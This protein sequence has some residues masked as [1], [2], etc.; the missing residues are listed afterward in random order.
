MASK[1]KK[2]TRKKELSL[3]EKMQVIHAEN[4]KKADEELKKALAEREVRA[5]KARDSLSEL[6]D[7]SIDTLK[8]AHSLECLGEGEHKAWN[9]RLK[10]ALETIKFNGFLYDPNKSGENTTVINITNLHATKV[11]S[12]AR[13]GKDG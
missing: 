7:K 10:A 3:A 6:L 12:L 8:S 13:L 11:L 5:E 1:T 4:V 2:P 9:I